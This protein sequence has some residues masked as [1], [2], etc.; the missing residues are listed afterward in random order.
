MEI[1]DAVIKD[2]KRQILLK[3]VTKNLCPFK[4]YVNLFRSLFQYMN[5]LFCDDTDDFNFKNIFQ[6]LNIDLLMYLNF[7]N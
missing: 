1:F 2:T 4:S 7:L 5:A 3:T 6:I